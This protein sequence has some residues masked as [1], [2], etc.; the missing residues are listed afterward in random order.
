MSEGVG[1]LIV[2]P[3]DTVELKTIEFLLQ[4]PYLLLYAT[5]WESLH[6]NSPII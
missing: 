2:S 4:P 1:C 5:M 6:I 3:E